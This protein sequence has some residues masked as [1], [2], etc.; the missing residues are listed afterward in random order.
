L[1]LSFFIQPAFFDT[2]NANLYV[3]INE[4]GL[5]YIILENEIFV[6][7]AVYQFENGFKDDAS[8]AYIHQIIKEQPV[9]L[10]KFNAVH[11]LYSFTS[12]ILVP[13]RFMKDLDQNAAIQLVYGD[14]S[15]RVIRTEFIYPHAIQ[16]IYGIPA[17]VNKVLS[18]YFG[19]AAVNHIYTLLPNLVKDPGNHL[20][21]I[22]SAGNLKIILM[23]D[24]K[25]QVIQ[26]FQYGTPGDVA[27]CLLNL[28]KCFGVDEQ[29][30]NV[31]LCGMIDA[32]SALYK[33]LHKY[34]L[35]MTFESL[36][37]QYQYP[38]AI[39]QYPA[40]YFSHLFSIATCV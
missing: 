35:L 33:E 16:N 23:K 32:S 19:F 2:A 8:A 27:Y 12:S 3:E 7:L 18:R 25:L 4:Q 22:F 6:A 13:Q 15:E 26:N 1:K 10:E 38:E 31:R 17:E 36:P 24:G 21:C 40:H 9:L 29:G 28:C 34:F 39:H 11:L 37:A 20:Y 30:I 5:S 14:A